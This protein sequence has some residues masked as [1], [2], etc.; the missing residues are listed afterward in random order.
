M[1]DTDLENTSDTGS[2]TIQIKL[3]GVK[4]YNDDKTPFDFVI[5]VLIRHFNVSTEQAKVFATTVHEDGR[6]VIGEYGKQVAVTKAAL[7]L[8][9]AKSFNFPLRV[10]VVQR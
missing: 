8:Q 6:G 2:Q 4:F 7:V 10:E 9:E 3:F 1:T 5:S